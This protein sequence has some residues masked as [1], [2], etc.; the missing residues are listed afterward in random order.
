MTNPT[1]KLVDHR[2]RQGLAAV[3]EGLRLFPGTL[4]ILPIIILQFGTQWS[5]NQVMMPTLVTRVSNPGQASEA[6]ERVD[7][8]PHFVKE[9]SE[10]I[11]GV[12]LLST[13]ALE[14]N[15]ASPVQTFDLAAQ[16]DCNDQYRVLASGDDRVFRE[17]WTLGQSPINGL[18]TRDQ[19][20][21]LDAPVT[22]LRI[23]PKEGDGLYSVSGLRIETQKRIRHTLVVPLVWAAF[24]VIR[25]LSR[26]GSAKRF[27]A[28]VMRSWAKSDWLVASG[29]ICSVLLRI[30]AASFLLILVA[31]GAGLVIG[32][33]HG[34]VRRFGLAVTLVNLAAA[35]GLLWIGPI[36]FNAILM[37]RIGTRINLTVDHRMKPDGQEINSDGIRFKGEARDV[38]SEDYNILFMGDSYTYGYRL[39]YEETVPATFEKLADSRC[40]DKIKSFNLGWISSSPLLSYRLLADIGKKYHP[41]LIVY[42]LDLTDYHDDLSYAMRLRQETDAPIPGGSPTRVVLGQILGRF[43]DI[44]TLNEF[45]SV[46][47]PRINQQQTSSSSPVPSDRFFIVNQELEESRNDIERGVI[48]NLS[49]IQQFGSRVL[50]APLAVVLVPR[51][52][53]YSFR[54]SPENWEKGA[55]EVGGPNVRV[56]SD[57]FEEKRKELGYPVLDLLPVFEQSEI[58]PLYFETDPHWNQRGALLAAETIE[59]FLGEEGL[60]PCR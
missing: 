54:E 52:F 14:M 28:W 44:E 60:L 13:E 1:L 53:Q 31:L 3:S 43:F 2:A 42:L 12:E 50:N 19:S 39:L 22:V 58:F 33:C 29:L 7:D 6:R 11:R 57:Y 47:R 25:S 36:L 46:L 15:F 37:H 8:F 56:P 49:R 16:A 30:D 59:S 24:L 10:W 5:Y 45:R 38:K 51:G 20:L 27:G 21:S 40:S 4:L 18:V 17:I 55:Y 9:G 35:V 41:D 32:V 26:Q 48:S 23:V 34:C